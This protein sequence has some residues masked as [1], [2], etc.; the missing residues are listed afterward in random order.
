MFSENKFSIVLLLCLGAAL[1]Y[2][3]HSATHPVRE[4]ASEVNPAPPSEF[5]QVKK[6]FETLAETDYAEYLKLKSEAEKYKKA[7]EI[8]A[9]IMNIFLADLGL[10]IKLPPASPTPTSTPTPSA[11]PS[12]TA[13]RALHS[14]S[15]DPVPSP[16]PLPRYS[17]YNDSQIA[18]FESTNQFQNPKQSLFD[19]KPIGPLPTALFGCFQGEVTLTNQSTQAM[20]ISIFRD[21]SGSSFK[22]LFLKNGKPNGHYSGLTQFFFLTNNPKDRN[23]FI[24]DVNPAQYFQ[25]FYLSTLNKIVGN[26][27]E[28]QV[29]GSFKFT[30]T[31]TLRGT[32]DCE[33]VNDVVW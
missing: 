3:I 4:S 33:W 28:A 22:L 9:K 27:Y 16:P 12:A 29:D 21:T 14:N 18:A 1:G 23:Q 13:S 25:L 6:K 30:G 26:K 32:R 15:M 10:H 5:D 11:T 7:D 17:V 2:G 24:L 19:S 31:V 8:L 20:K